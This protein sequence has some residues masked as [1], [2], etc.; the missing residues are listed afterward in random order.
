[1]S[2]IEHR[3]LN[4]ELIAQ[5]AIKNIFKNTKIFE[6]IFNHNSLKI[7]LTNSLKIYS[8]NFAYLLKNQEQSIC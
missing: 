3:T 4:I 8:N 6:N 7:N 1:M 2:N 5:T